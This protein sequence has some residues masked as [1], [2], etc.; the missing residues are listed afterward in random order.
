MP[1]QANR[2]PGRGRVSRRPRGPPR[3]R[4]ADSERIRTFKQQAA[5]DLYTAEQVTI[6][7]PEAGKISSLHVSGFRMTNKGSF[8]AASLDGKDISF[9]PPEAGRP[10][11]LNPAAVM[12]AD[13]TLRDITFATLN[14]SATLT[15]ME[16]TNFGAGRQSRLNLSEFAAPV[17]K[18]RNIDHVGF[19]SLALS[20]I[21]LASAVNAAERHTMMP[22]PPTGRLRLVVGGV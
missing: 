4:S 20:G 14:T 13:L 3:C 22:Q 1:G 19:A 8:T 12:F 7:S 6:V 17:P 21:D 11:I 2:S 18:G 15:S 9:P 5:N 10:F 16:V